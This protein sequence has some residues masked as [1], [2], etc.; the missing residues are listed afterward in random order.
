VEPCGAGGNVVER[1]PLSKTRWCP[2]SL[3]KLVQIS[4]ITMVFVGDIS[5]VNGDYKL[6][7]NW[8]AP[9]CTALK[10]AVGERCDQ[11]VNQHHYTYPLE[12]NRNLNIMYIYI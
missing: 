3:A 2:S 12:L 4:P 10:T 9:P 1:R 6:I 11:L 5:I 8:G 7:Y